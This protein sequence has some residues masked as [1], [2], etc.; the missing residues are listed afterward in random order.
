MSLQH[1]YD[2]EN[3]F[4]KIIAGDIPSATVFETDKVLAFMDAFPQSEGHSLVIPK[5]S[6][7]TNL[8][9]APADLLP[10]VIEGTQTLARA[11]KA[12]LSPDGIRIAQFNGAAAGQTVFHLHFHV[13][14]VWETR[15]TAP[16]GGGQAAFADLERVAEKIK[17]AL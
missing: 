1:S 3:V 15:A 17:A 8:L 6:G 12:A 10:A 16:H 14:P 5:A 13:I 4:A 2:P 9:E 11:V 7:I